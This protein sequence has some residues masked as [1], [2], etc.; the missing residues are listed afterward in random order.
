MGQTTR[1]VNPMRRLLS[2]VAVTAMIVCSLIGTAS[3]HGGHHRAAARQCDSSVCM[4]NGVCD[5]SC[6]GTG[7]CRNYDGCNYTGS[8]AAVCHSHHGHH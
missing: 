5:G 6:T 7:S 3:A 1:K 8:S 4:V 2:S